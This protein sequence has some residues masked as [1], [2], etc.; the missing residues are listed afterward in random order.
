MKHAPYGYDAERKDMDVRGEL[1]ILAIWIVIYIAI[2][3]LAMLF[4]AIG[5]HMSP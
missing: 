3:T 1:T 4:T 2:M 5:F